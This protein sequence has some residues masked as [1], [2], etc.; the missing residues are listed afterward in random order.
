MCLVLFLVVMAALGGSFATIQIRQSACRA[1]EQ[2]VNDRMVKA[3]ESIKQF[4][5]LQK[6]RKEMMKT[7]LTTAEL[8][9]PVPRSILLAS[10]TN[11]LPPGV[12]LLKLDFIQ[13]EPKKAPPAPVKSKFQAAQASNK[14][15]KPQPVVSREKLLETHIDMTGTA[16]S[17]LEVASF[18]ER[19]SYSTL[20]SDVALVE[21]KERKVEDTTFRQF[22]LKAM[23]AKGIHLTSDDVDK[24]RQGGEKSIYRF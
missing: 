24:I 11:N 23:L 3:R 15:P 19:L 8:L 9:E 2:L 1:Q 5:E 12:S 6:R 16:P 13:K 7:A 10:L 21:S 4:E 14:P 22:K 17:D 20:L 18:I